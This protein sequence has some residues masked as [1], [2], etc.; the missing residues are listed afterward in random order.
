MEKPLSAKPTYNDLE[1]RV[2]ELEKEVTHCRKMQEA[3]WAERRQLIALFKG[4][5]AYV[6]L[7][8]PNH[9]IC[10][11]NDFFR[12]RF[13]DPDGRRCADFFRTSIAACPVPGILENMQPR[14]W[15]WLEASD[16]GA[17][18][19]YDYP[20][21]AGQQGEPM[22]LELGIDVAGRQ[23]ADHEYQLLCEE[24]QYAIG[25][26]RS[27]QSVVPICSCCRQPRNDESHRQQVNAYI[28]NHA[29]EPFTFG[30]C[31]S[32]REKYFLCLKE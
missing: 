18:R 3:I 32:C 5:P 28:Q 17:Y 13:G 16:G 27:L 9:T 15:D 11:A 25:K 26:L 10:Y 22:V 21:A 19:V 23:P 1:A 29:G 14:T 4:F 12:E 31:P 7:E 30:L 20:F 24:F 6:C 2:D 8:A